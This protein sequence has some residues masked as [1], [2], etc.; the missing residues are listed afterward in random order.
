MHWFLLGSF[1]DGVIG[2]LALNIV[3]AII[4]FVAIFLLGHL[5]AFGRISQIKLLRWACAS[6]V[7][8]VRSIPL[9]IILFWFYFSIPI[10]LNCTPSPILSGLMALS[11]YAA[12]Y[13]AE[14]IRSGINTVSAGELDAARSL[15]LSRSTTLFQ[16]I[17]VQA[18]K[19]MLPTYASYFTSLFKD[20]S[21]LYILGLVELMQAGLIVAERNPGEMFQ[22]YMTMGSL[23]FI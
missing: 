6:Y 18:H 3:I 16:V 20:T 4:A 13:Q 2:G 15:G 1:P 21:A 22:V 14:Y 12:A 5:L 19:R 8:L 23:F 10:L 7:E 9:V 17:L 11:F